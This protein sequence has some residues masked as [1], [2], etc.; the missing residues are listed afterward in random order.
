MVGP[1][2]SF[3]LKNRDFTRR[4]SES[5]DR[6]Q[7]ITFNEFRDEALFILKDTALKLVQHSYIGNQVGGYYQGLDMVPKKYGFDLVAKAPYSSQVET[8]RGPLFSN[9]K[10]FMFRGKR[11]NP[12]ILDSLL[13]ER[14]VNK[15]KAEKAAGAPLNIPK[16][17]KKATFTLAREQQHH[18]ARNMFELKKQVAVADKKS[19]EESG[20]VMDEFFTARKMVRS[21]TRLGKVYPY[22]IYTVFSQKV[23]GYK[24]RYVLR[25]AGK[26]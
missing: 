23:R 24:G 9:G 6:A 18:E 3:R 22:G 2:I 25:E 8:G 21:G 20:A 14:R 1:T 17:T 4:V 13:A 15:L 19:R 5:A 12:K 11:I 26:R 16:L 7:G 10:P